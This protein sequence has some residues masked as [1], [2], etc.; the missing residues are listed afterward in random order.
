MRFLINQQERFPGWGWGVASAVSEILLGILTITFWP[1]S[2][3]FVLGT[4]V[5]V[6]LIFSGVSAF[7]VGLAVRRLLAHHEE[8][9]RH[10]RPATRF[11]H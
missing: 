2:S 3:V 4:I 1:T 9:Q 5:G 11:Q 8:P 6:Q 7:N 10:D